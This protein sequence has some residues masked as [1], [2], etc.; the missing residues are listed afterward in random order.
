MLTKINNRQAVQT[1][2]RTIEP[3]LNGDFHLSEGALRARDWKVGMYESAAYFTELTASR[4]SMATLTY[5]RQ[6]ILGLPTENGKR[7]CQ[8]MLRLESTT[9]DL[10]SLNGE[11]PLALVLYPNPLD[12]LVLL[13][14]DYHL[15]AGS[16]WFVENAIGEST[17]KAYDRLANLFLTQEVPVAIRSVYQDLE[18]Y[19]PFV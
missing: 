13:T 11:Y 9:S 10:L 4:L 6:D 14:P 5:D 15:I 19:L 7:D 17:R 3:F 2:V 1:A 12:F 16:Q 18:R 8:Y